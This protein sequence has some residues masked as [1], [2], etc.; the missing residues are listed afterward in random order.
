MRHM[1]WKR[2]PRNPILTRES[3]PDI[4]PDLVDPTSVFNPGAVSIK[5]RTVL[6]LR[7][8]TR[9]RRTLLLR[10][11]SDDGFHFRPSRSLVTLEGLEAAGETVHHVYDPRIS[12]LGGT[13][14]VMVAMDTDA[15]CRLGLAR[16]ADFQTLEFMGVVSDG[17]A[18][19]GVLFP[20]KVGGRFLR[21]DRP[22]DVRRADGSTSGS[23]I[24]LSA[25]DDLLNWESLG[26][27]IRGRPHYWDELIGSGPP[28][29]KTRQ[30]WLHVYHGIATH[31][32]SGSIYQAGVLLL[33]L[34]DPT[35]VLA[36]SRNNCLEP[37]EPYELVG[38]VPN[39]VFP[40]GMVVAELDDEGFALD[41]SEVRLYY[42]AADTCIALATAAV[43]DVLGMCQD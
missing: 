41:D 39:V 23:E 9:G 42:G 34:K 22:N 28:P 2:S 25:S 8:Q 6:L 33:D 37:R 38:Q 35:K 13:H 32:A 36:R 30:G 43:R 14:Y 27:V 15:G 7:V 31:G 29:I 16:T 5:G 19:N 40:T 24:R 4:A 26:P 11:S 21:F 12:R 17:D 20:E 1:G 18:R 3:I 10:A